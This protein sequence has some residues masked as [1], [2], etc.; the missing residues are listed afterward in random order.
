MKTKYKLFLSGEFS[1]WFPSIFTVDGV[2]FNCGEQYMMYCKAMFFDDTETA[3]KILKSKFPF[4]QKE[5]G[6]KVKN[7]NDKQW[8]NVR[9]ELV[10]KGIR[11]KFTQNENL[12]KFMLS[13]KGY[14][15]VEVNPKDRIWGVGY[16]K[17][18]A[19]DNIDDWGQNLL[20][21]MLTEICNELS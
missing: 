17:F 15:M 13:H 10:K 4:E 14:Q 7:Y 21:K 9:Y 3:D 2:R 5:L 6:R 8:N 20:G 18:N 1:N 16:S 12:K 11:E 19:L